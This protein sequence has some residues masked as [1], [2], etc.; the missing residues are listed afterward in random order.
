MADERQIY[1][2]PTVVA[3]TNTKAVTFTVVVNAVA[4]NLTG[5]T[6]VIKFKK[7]NS[8]KDIQKTLAVGT[9]ITIT[10]AVGGIFRVDSFVMDW[11]PDTYL[12]DIDITPADG[13]KRNW[14]KGKWVVTQNI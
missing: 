5:A 2:F 12:F 3:K 13:I 8:V 10:N 1:D 4:M 11:K 7:W 6:I 14:L 9:G